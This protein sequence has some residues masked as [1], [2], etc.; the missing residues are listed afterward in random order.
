MLSQFIHNCAAL[1][2]CA[3]RSDLNGLLHFS[4][5]NPDPGLSPAF[6]DHALKHLLLPAH[7]A[8]PTAS[9]A[10]LNRTLHHHCVRLL[11]G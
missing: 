2:S 5:K 11:L 3:A 10:M 8:N 6:T 7:L 1:H 9:D 4:T